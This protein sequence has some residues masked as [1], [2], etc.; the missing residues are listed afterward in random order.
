MKIPRAGYGLL[1]AALFGASTPLAKLSIQGIQPLMLAG[2]LYLGSGVGLMIAISFIGVS[3][4]KELKLS[5]LGRSE[6]LYLLGAIVFG[7][8]LAPVLLMIGLTRV[9]GAIASLLLNLEGALTALIACLVFHERYERR[10]VIGLIFIVSGGIVLASAGQNNFQGSLTGI[11][12]IAG[13]CASWAIDNNFTNQVKS[14]DAPILAAVKG[15]SSGIVNV[16]LALIVGQT[17]PTIGKTAVAAAIGFVGYGLSLVFFILSLRRIGAARTSAYFSTAPFVGAALSLAFLHE[18][19]H[20]R[21][22]IAGALMA[23]GVYLHL[24]ETPLSPEV[25]RLVD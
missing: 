9:A 14:I 23:V 19:M 18:P 13:A 11:L 22:G 25:N 21:L 2:L 3:K 4:F 17:F 1:A 6:I 7:G 10:L 16:T 20:L 5:E 12:F 8:M 24:T 15:L